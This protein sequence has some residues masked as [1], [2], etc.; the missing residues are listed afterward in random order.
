MYICF[1]ASEELFSI[2]APES[3]PMCLGDDG[4]KSWMDVSAVSVEL[5]EQM[6]YW[7]VEEGAGL[8]SDHVLI[9]LELLVPTPQAQASRCINWQKTDWTRFHHNLQFRM[10]VFNTCLLG[11]P[12][13]LDDAI[14]RSMKMLQ[15]MVVAQVPFQ[16]VCSHSRE[17]WTPKIQDLRLCMWRAAHQ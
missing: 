11:T 1:L 5:L 17:W 7:Q 12:A 9:T 15:Q 8:G 6:F 13:Q 3:P 14:E 10:Q 2:N 4:H 16:R